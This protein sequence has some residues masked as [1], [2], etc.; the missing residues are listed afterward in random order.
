MIREVSDLREAVALALKAF[1]CNQDSTKATYPLGNSEE[2][3]VDSFV[4]MVTHE[5]DVILVDEEE[6]IIGILAL[7][8]EPDRR[9]I[10]AMGG[11]YAFK[12]FNETTERFLD[13][14]NKRYPNY[15]LQ[16]NMSDKNVTLAEALLDYGAECIEHCTSYYS[17]LGIHKPWDYSNVSFLDE[18]DREEF[19]EFHNHHNPLMYWRGQMIV[20]RDDMFDI[21]ICKRDEKIVCSLVATNYEGEAEIY[22]LSSDENYRSLNVQEETLSYLLQVYFNE[23]DVTE[24]NAL[25]DFEDVHEAKAYEACGFVEEDSEIGYRLQLGGSVA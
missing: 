6:E 22:A 14:L 16:F 7:F 13:Y 11:I 17:N 25:V 24:V 21:V 8:V 1:E 12:N 4:K 23:K 10:Q 15:T 9:F 18:E 19:I 20:E 2:E 5:S 3:V